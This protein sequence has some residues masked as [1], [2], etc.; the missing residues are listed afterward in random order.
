VRATWRTR[1]PP[2]AAEW[3]RVDV[4]DEA[5]MRAAAD[6]IDAVVHTA[7]DHGG[8]W[9]TNVD[10]AATVAAAASH[11][12][13]VHLS[14]DLVFDGAR[15]R[16]RETDE[17]A[18]VNA[19]GCSKLAAERRVVAA[20]PQA[21]VVRTSLIYGRPDGRQERLARE[22]TRFFVDERRSPVHVDDLAAA[23]L[24]LLDLDVPG[25][26]H[27]A[28]ADDVSRYELALLLGADPTRIEEA[29]TTS[30]RAPDVTLDCSRAASTLRT[31]LR[32]VYEVRVR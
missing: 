11:A 12:R 15:G 19:Y 10:A 18:P 17:P 26:L 6:G 21:T 27:V 1:R 13:L 16:Y 30:D 24:E 23:V 32:G 29:H 5:A 28:G 25:P 7:V 2:L 9:T 20:H 14:T 4:R 31:R 3:V 22:G 8:D